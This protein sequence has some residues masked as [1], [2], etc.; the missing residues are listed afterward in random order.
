MTVDFPARRGTVTTRNDRFC[1]A[2]A[3]S[4]AAICGDIVRLRTN[5]TRSGSGI[6]HPFAHRID[7]R[8][9]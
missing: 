5:S 7:V 8:V 9:R 1:S 2:V 4:V 3:Q 6:G